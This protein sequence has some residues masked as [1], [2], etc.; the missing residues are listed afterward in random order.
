MERRNF[1][2]SAVILPAVGIETNPKTRPKKG[3]KVAAGTARFQRS[4]KVGAAV[5]DCKVSGKDTDG[6]LYIF[7]S[8]NNL[9]NDGPPLHSHPDL[10]E[11]FYILEGEMKFKVGDEIFY[12]KV[13]DSVLI[14]RNV[15]HCFTSNT[16]KPA[17]MLVIIQSA[18]TMESFFEELSK[19]E[20]IT[21][22][23]GAQIYQKHNMVLLGPPLM[24]D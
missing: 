21:P 9:K 13:G 22:E 4:L 5:L 1:I 6:D 23:I 12:M 11:T 7:E 3:V 8:I 18:T 15:P 24:A 14:P 20:K 16:D 19:V 17:K 2:K 10:D